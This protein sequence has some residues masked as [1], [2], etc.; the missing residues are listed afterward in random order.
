MDDHARACLG[1]IRCAERPGVAG[2][3][4]MSAADATAATA[5]RPTSW[6]ERCLEAASPSRSRTRSPASAASPMPI[7]T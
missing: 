5:R 6:R 1:A 3:R 7:S 4:A 2:P